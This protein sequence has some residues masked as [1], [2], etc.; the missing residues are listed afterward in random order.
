MA[1]E[2]LTPS[3]NPGD[4]LMLTLSREGREIDA[5]T[6]DDGTDAVRI[7]VQIIANQEE[8][9]LGDTLEVSRV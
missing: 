1:N 4:P 8:L 7:A 5:R 9:H 6:A 2:N 3:R